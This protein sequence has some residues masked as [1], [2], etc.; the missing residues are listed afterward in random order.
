MT[1][2]PTATEDPFFTPAP[3]PPEPVGRVAFTVTTRYVINTDYEDEIRKAFEAYSDGENADDYTLEGILLS[4]HFIVQMGD[5]TNFVL[6]TDLTVA[7]DE[8]TT[9]PGRVSKCK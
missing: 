3:T 6:E 1:D 8:N 9:I 2:T 7:V 5:L 4:L